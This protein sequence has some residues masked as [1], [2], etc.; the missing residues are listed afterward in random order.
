MPVREPRFPGAVI[1]TLLIAIILTIIPLG[2]QLSFWR[3]EWIALTFVHWALII[4]DRI[5]LLLAF[6]VGLAVDTLFGSIL[7]QHALGYL[8]VA[9]LSV[10]LGLRMTPE[11]FLQQIALLGAVL[12][13]Y[14]LI[15]LW[16][17]GVTGNGSG[18]LLYWA[19]MFSSIVVWP[20]YHALLGYFHIQRKAL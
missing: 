12:G 20:V 14:M 16:I 13:L 18:G 8:L 5:S 2:E 19:S 15:N 6:V 7:G 9:Y 1:V 10:R 17:Q 11:A 3:P 4:Q